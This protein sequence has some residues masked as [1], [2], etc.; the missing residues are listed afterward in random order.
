[1]TPITGDDELVEWT[2]DLFDLV[3]FWEMFVSLSN[4]IE[5]LCVLPSFFEMNNVTRL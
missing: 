1:M 2:L 4:S 3:Q 5:I